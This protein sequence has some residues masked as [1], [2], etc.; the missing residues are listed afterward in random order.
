MYRFPLAN[1]SD[2]AWRTLL[3]SLITY[4]REIQTSYDQRSK[5]L[6]KVS[7]VIQNLQTPSVFMSNGGLSDANRVL[8]DYHRHSLVEANK[9]KDIE[10]DVIQALSGLRSDL[11]QKIKEIK[12]LSGDF[13]NSVDREKDN[14]KKAI[15]T[16]AEAL[17]DSEHGEGAR[18]DPFLVRLGVDRSIEKQ[19]DEENYLHRVCAASL[20]TG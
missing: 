16:Y 4:F 6:V 15:S 3:K 5:A 20:S 18:T 1:S 13:K 10:A 8:A 14:T 19:I 11:A 2:T 17:H 7:N 12:S 9:S